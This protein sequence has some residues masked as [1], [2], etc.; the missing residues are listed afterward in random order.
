MITAVAVHARN[1]YELLDEKAT[2]ENV[3]GLAVKVF[4]GP[5]TERY[6][7]AHISKAY[8]SKIIRLLE[9]SGAISFLQKGARFQQSVIL[10]NGEPD[11]DK[12]AELS[13]QPL[14]GATSSAMVQLEQRVENLEKRLEG[15]DLVSLLKNYEERLSALEQKGS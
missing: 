8:Y 5:L 11:L 4:R 7:A 10:L 12:L 13:P 1:L 9:D 2:M 15:L 3:D 14:T 6:K